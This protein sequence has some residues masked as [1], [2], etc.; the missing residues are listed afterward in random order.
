MVTTDMLYLPLLTD[1]INIMLSNYRPWDYSH[2]NNYT[3]PHTTL[4]H[5]QIDELIRGTY[6]QA[7][8]IYILYICRGHKYA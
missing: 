5:H 6:Q 2:N 8:F 1:S 4:A 3:P 7:R